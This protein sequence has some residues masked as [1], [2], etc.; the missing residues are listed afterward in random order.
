MALS[1]EC[2]QYILWRKDG[3]CVG[4]TTYHIHVP[5]FWKFLKPEL[6]CPPPLGPVQVLSGMTTFYGA[7]VTDTMRTN[8][9]QRHE[10]DIEETERFP[11]VT[12]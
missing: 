6:P 5:N 9:I 2:Q 11:R 8:Y 12:D 3:R 7:I 10:I 1:N 4:L